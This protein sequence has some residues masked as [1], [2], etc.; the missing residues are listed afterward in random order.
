MRHPPLFAT[1]W[2][3]SRRRNLNFLVECKVV[4]FNNELTFTILA[5]LGLSFSH[6][7]CPDSFGVADPRFLDAAKRRRN[8]DGFGSPVPRYS[9]RELA[10]IEQSALINIEM[11]QDG[12]CAF[13]NAEERIFGDISSDAETF[14]EKFL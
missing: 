8:R 9:S 1:G 13:G 4:R 14:F 11:A 5:N 3:K 12:G 10:S 6:N 7:F 2:A